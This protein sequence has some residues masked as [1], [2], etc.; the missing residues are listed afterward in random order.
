[1]TARRRSRAK[2]QAL[3]EFA[4]VLPVFLLILF[5]IFDFG[6]AIYSYNAISNAARE[7]GRTAII[8]QYPDAVRA[9]AAQQATAVGLPT[10]DPGNCPSGGGPT[11]ATSGVCFSLRTGANL[12]SACPAPPTL[13]CV[14]VVNVKT[15]FTALTP[16]IGNIV[17]P[18]PITAETKQ[19]IEFVCDTSSCATR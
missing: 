14:A 17:G 13:G 7:G 3:V 1:M 19:I 11:T 12:S 5:V 15:T 6:R 18:I 8:N 16:I 2:A 9:K 10:T 4:L